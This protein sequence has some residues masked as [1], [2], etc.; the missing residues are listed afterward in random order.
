MNKIWD[1]VAWWVGSQ[2]DL[3]RKYL[4]EHSPLVALLAIVAIAA[5]GFELFNFNLTIDEEI[6]AFSSQAH[7]WIGQGRWGMFLLNT[8]LIPYPIIPFVPLFVALV[9]HIAAVLI[10][11]RAWGVESK[12]QAAAVGCIAVSFP[13]M[14]YLYTFSTL[15]Y[16]IG[17][18]LFLAALS[19]V[20]FTKQS[21][22][23]QFLAVIPGT[24]SISIYQGFSVALVCVY[25][26][27]FLRVELQSSNRTID[28]R[29]LLKM[30]SVLALS[31]VAYYFVQKLFLVISASRIIYIDQYFDVAFARDHF[32][33]VLRRT[34]AV[35]RRVY[36]GSPAV[37]ANRITALAPIVVASVIGVA[38]ALRSSSLVAWN[39]LLI[40]LLVVGAL[41][42][43][44]AMGLFMK[45][46]V[47]IRFL[48]AVPFVFAG[49]AMLGMR[50]Y[51]RNVQL[52]MSIVVGVCVFQFVLSTNSLFSSSHLAL[53]ADRAL[54]AML[55]ARIEEVKD[56]A[57]DGEPKYYEVIGYF[58][59]APTNLIPKSGTF[60]ASFFEWEEG[61]AYR[62]GGFLRTLGFEGLNPLPEE[63][64]IQFTSMAM[65]MPAWPHTGSVTAVGDTMLIKFG[66]YST[67]Q[68]Q[69]ICESVHTKEVFC[70]Q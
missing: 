65:S 58:Q 25:L 7:T 50:A 9:F 39:K 2:G 11:L 44:F 51:S 48:V 61:N 41:L 24:F 6:H 70:E 45:G 56:S 33:S 16:G 8:L 42:L 1:D 13:T 38:A 36:L 22:R 35:A 59:R 37:Y 30:V 28:V 63:R 15:N 55:L 12:L 52:L 34:L 3:V 26:I 4:R 46:D 57:G 68:R 49:F 69:R 62:I 27:Q 54:G 29:N 43:P 67:I 31:A 40:G 10:L 20:L 32:G 19:V 21:G 66:N 5:Y 53:Q 23:R 64:R 60:G 14:A 47:A 18:G 17:I